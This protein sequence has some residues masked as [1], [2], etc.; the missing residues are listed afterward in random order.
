MNR[1]TFP[2][3]DETVYSDV[4]DNGLTVYLL[5]KEGYEKTYAT[6]TT[7][8]GSIDRRF[9]A[10]EWQTVPDGIAHFLE[11]KMFE[12]EDGDVFQLF[13]K[14]GA[15]ANAFTSFTRTAYLFSATANVAENLETLLDFVQAPYFTE[16]TVEK[17]KGIIGQEIQMYQDNPGWR[18]YFGMIQG[19]YQTHPV[20]IDIAGTIESIAAI[21]AED[22]YTCHSAFYHPSNMMLFV[23]GN[24]DPEETMAQIRANQAA[25]Q[26]PPNPLLEREQIEEPFAVATPRRVIEM[27]VSVPK[28]MIGYKD[29]PASGRE[30]IKQ[31]LTVDLLMHALFDATSPIYTELYEEGLMDDAFSFG[32][33]LE[34]TFAFATFSM[35]TNREEAFIERMDDVLSRPFTVDAETLDRKRKMLIGKLLKALN[36]PEYIANQFSNYA[37][38]GGNMFEMIDVL[39]TI[40]LSDLESAYERLFDAERRAVCVVR[41][42]T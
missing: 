21:T 1:L 7:R 2:K 3:V 11:H 4:L 26:F 8:Y 29:E 12:K 35:E 36:S 15:S 31:E 6:F 24:V 16:E 33:T 9:K 41:R 23:V 19:L 38:N 30:A 17:E 32:Y 27:D 20:N 10:P 28:V 13:G 14:Q 5:K 18:L 25:K 40:T 42:T 39:E 22:L 37:L 34:E